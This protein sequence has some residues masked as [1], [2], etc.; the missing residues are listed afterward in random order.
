MSHVAKHLPKVVLAVAVVTMVGV[1]LLT[2]PV[3]SKSTAQVD[4]EEQTWLIMMYMDADDS[5]LEREI[6]TDLNEAE[7]IGSSDRVQIVAQI[8]RFAGGFD[9]DGDWTSTKRYY[10][11]Q[12][13]DLTTL[14]SEEVMD[15]GE[16]NMAD[17][18]TLVDFVNWAVESYPADKYVLILSDHGMG[19]PGGWSD[20]DPGGF[21]RHDIALA[22]YFEDSLYLMEIDDALA[23]ARSQ[24][25][26][27]KFEIVGFDACLMGHL[28]V[29]SA[30]APHAN[31]MLASQELEPGI[32]WAY[33]AFLEKLNDQPEMDGAELAQTI[34]ETY[35]SE[36]QQYINDVARGEYVLQAYEFEQP[37]TVEEA[38][39]VFT[40]AEL[41]AD[42]LASG[43]LAAID[44]AAVSDVVAAL[45]N[46]TVAM[47][48]L[49][50]GTVAQAR[51]YAQ[52]YAS[53]FGDDVPP[54]YIDLVHFALVLQ[55]QAG[56]DVNL[57]SN[58]DALVEAMA[59]AVIAEKHGAQKSGSNGLSIYFPNSELYGSWAA[60]YDS[61]TT[62][63]N[64]FA[65]ES[66]WD[67]F[68]LT[69]YTGEILPEPDIAPT[70][71]P[72]PTVTPSPQGSA[73]P[74][75]TPLVVTVTPGVQV[76]ATPTRRPT[77]TPSIDIVA[78]GA[79]E[80]EIT[81]LT[82]LADV[83]SMD[84]PLLLDTV[85]VGD[86]I[87]FI[88]F[89]AGYYDEES[90]SII[91]ADLDFV[92]AEAVTEIEGVFY[93]DWGDEGVVE[94]EFEWLPEIFVV[95]DGITSEFVVLT[96]EDYG[97]TPEETIYSVE[98]IFSSADGSDE[99]YA[100]M[101]FDGDGQFVSLYGYTGE[102]GTGAP[103]E[104]NPQPDDAFIILMDVLVPD[105]ETGELEF[106]EVEGGTLLF[107]DTPFEWFSEPAPPGFYEV[108]F[109][110][111]DFDGNST[112]AYTEVEVIE[113]E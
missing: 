15:V 18:D 62:V 77:P 4:P 47:S 81:E 7:M 36:D 61:Y 5:A 34:V 14:G 79:G 86:Q 50:Q 21:G 17:L 11:T 59:T 111:E 71:T 107:G 24:S 110:V 95:D 65:V 41:A 109:I 64:R 57:S 94:M 73:T 10:V 98:G 26:I 46:M 27:D 108:G 97:A 67:D 80:I 69:H 88:Y 51:A 6:F 19:W 87:G 106:T 54:S 39:T 2:A 105:E 100:T 44:L 53:V 23:Q 37:L 30:I 99:R 38:A 29:A 31:Y 101:Y 55:K 28:E 16:T 91:V 42:E 60:G 89:Y 76:T 72:S 85:I 63:A 35:I 13:D 45:N 75:A 1:W 40:P 43:T 70:A 90:D 22:Q 92:D 9:G 96:P 93:P 103:R 58:V 83:A 102:N 56:E 68:L 66:L 74:T 113:V 104:I 84:E 48:L 112:E 78:P 12:D 32:G 49:D 8:D 82:P 3:S 52:S 33:A 20:P 25:G